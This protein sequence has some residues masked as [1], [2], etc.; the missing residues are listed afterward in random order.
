MYDSLRTKTYFSEGGGE[1]KQFLG[2]NVPLGPWNRKPI[3]ELV[4][5]NFARVNSP[6][7][8]Y[9]G[10]A[11]FEKLLRSLAQSSLDK[12]FNQLISFLKNDSLF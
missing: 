10:V 6:S 3:P 11:V 8:P 2:G 12:I 4:Q 1:L 5:L 7:P 9:P